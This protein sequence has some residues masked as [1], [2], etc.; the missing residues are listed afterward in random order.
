MNK[1]AYFAGAYAPGSGLYRMAMKKW[2][3]IPTAAPVVEEKVAEKPVQKPK[4][5]KKTAK[6]KTKE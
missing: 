4:A 3:A 2:G 1:E 5:A 6:K